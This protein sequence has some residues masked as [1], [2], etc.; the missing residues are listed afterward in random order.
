MDSWV[1]NLLSGLFGS[2][3]GITIFDLIYVRPKLKE[4]KA[5]ADKSETEAA[6]AKI[7]YLVERIEKAEQLYNEQGKLIDELRAKVLQLTKEVQ[8]KEEKIVLFEGENSKMRQ[9]LIQLKKEVEAYKTITGG[10]T[11][12]RKK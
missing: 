7:T 5:N 6:D 8:E 10:K 9:E 3:I 4:A 12:G 1:F 2:G 11:P